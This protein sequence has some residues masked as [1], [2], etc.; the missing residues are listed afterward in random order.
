[1]TSTVFSAPSTGAE[2]RGPSPQ[3]RVLPCGLTV[4]AES[5]PVEAIN[6]NIWFRVGSA[7]EPEPL[8]GVAHFLEHMVFKGSEALALGEFERRTEACG[9]K[10]NAATSQDYTHFYLTAS[11]QQFADLAPLQLEVVARPAIAASA[12][13]REKQVVLEEIRRSGDNPRRRIFQQSMDL[14]F[15]Q[16]PYRR[17]VLGP[18]ATVAALEPAQMREFH[19]A[20]YRPEWAT[21]VVVGNLPTEVLFERVRRAADQVWGA[22]RA[23]PPVPPLPHFEPEPPFT[24]IERRVVV[25]PTLQQARLALMWRVPGA[26]DLERT[27]PLDA[28]AAILGQGRLSRLVRDLREDRRLVSRI[29]ASNSSYRY[30][31]IFSIGAQL[32]PEHLETVEAA[33]VEHLERLHQEPVAAAD[34]ERIA[35]RVAN[36]FIF[37]N[38]TPSS[39]AALYGFYQTM[40]GRLE[41][42]LDYPKIMRRLDP[43]QLQA[44]VRRFLPTDAYRAL[45]VRPSP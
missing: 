7:L 30:Q 21:A 31:G 38:E 41:M 8:N 44:A 13:A 45:V 5:M 25:D 12:F 39:R 6:L 1:M 43:E 34:L 24:A 40:V 23:V 22:D 20:Y 9:A 36:G 2:R 37:N 4:V 17:S 16:L 19:G 32:P 18:A 14:A 29:S 28:I 42:A 15:E 27:H 35:R 10:I 33:I 3:V 26:I 11:P